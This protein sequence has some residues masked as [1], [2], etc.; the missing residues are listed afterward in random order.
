MIAKAV[1][2]LL[3]ALFILGTTSPASVLAQTYTCVDNCT[4]GADCAAGEWCDTTCDQITSVF[5]DCAPVPADCGDGTCDT[6][7][8]ENCA[9]CPADC[10]PCPWTPVPPAPAPPPAE[11][12]TAL[13]NVPTN[14]K[15]LAQWF[16]D[17]VALGLV[18]GI[19]VLRVAMGGIK[20][21]SSGGDPK[22]VEEGRDMVVS[23]LAGLV[24]IIAAVVV[25]RSFATALG[26]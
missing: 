19:A 25:I 4:S 3:A 17:H 21:M 14:P 11:V 26:I 16:I 8:G 12:E 15:D 20:I 23:T 6:T 10:P 9:S 5:G 2:S 18:G 7:V 1:F 24:L 13:G 22:A